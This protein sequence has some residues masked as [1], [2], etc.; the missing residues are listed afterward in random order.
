[1]NRSEE[2]IQPTNTVDLVTSPPAFT[3]RLLFAVELAL[4][5]SPLK[6]TVP[7]TEN[8]RHGLVVPIPTLPAPSITNRSFVPRAEDEA[9]LNFAASESSTPMVHFSFAPVTVEN[10]IAASAAFAKMVSFWFGVVVP[11]PTL[12]AK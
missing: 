12:A 2:P 11:M 5:V 1:M 7:F 10:S 9:I 6:A 8:V 4:V 3:Q